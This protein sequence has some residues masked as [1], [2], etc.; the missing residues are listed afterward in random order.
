M[1]EMIDSPNLVIR[2]KLNLTK[3][4]EFELIPPKKKKVDLLNEN[5]EEASNTHSV[6]INGNV[7]EMLEYDQDKIVIIAAKSV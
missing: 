2:F 6:I 5:F 1:R 3:S 7:P 4:D